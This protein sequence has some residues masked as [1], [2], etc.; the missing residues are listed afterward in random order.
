M[1]YFD[2]KVTEIIPNGFVNN[3]TTLV[4]IMFWCLTGDKVL[5]ESMVGWFIAPH[6]RHT[7]SVSR[8]MFLNMSYND[9]S[10]M[11]T[12]VSKISWNYF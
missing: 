1:L 11:S 7:D 5:S 6:M 2:S 8:Q 4:E 12:T 9:T 3:M 10:E